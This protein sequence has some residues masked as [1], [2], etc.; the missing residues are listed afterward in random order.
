MITAKPVSIAIHGGLPDQNHFTLGPA[1]FNIPGWHIFNVTDAITVLIGDK[2]GNPVAPGTAV[3]FTTTGGVIQGSTKTN[4]DG[5]G[6]VT[7]FSGN[8]L[9]EHPVLGKGFATITAETADENNNKVSGQ[10]I[11][12]FS[13]AP[14]LSVSPEAGTDHIPYGGIQRFNISLQDVNGNPMSSGT[15]I[16]VSVKGKNVEIDG[17]INVTMD[18]TQGRGPGATEFSF[19]VV[20]VAEPADRVERSISLTVKVEGPNGRASAGISTIVRE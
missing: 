8:P 9:P 19:F 15:T 7:L 18:D 4:N 12:L 14:I 2:Y 10:T 13:G 5:Q 11:V 17:D 20:D 1:K 3:Y 16:S 6:T